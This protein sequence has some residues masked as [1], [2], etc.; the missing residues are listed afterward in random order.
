MENI[1]LLLLLFYLYSTTFR[2]CS[3]VIFTVL[4]FV[5]VVYG[6]YTFTWSPLVAAFL[7]ASFS[8]HHT[9]FFSFH[10]SGNRAKSR[11]GVSS[12]IP[13]M[14]GTLETSH[15]S[16]MLVSLNFIALP[17]IH[18]TSSAPLM[19]PESEGTCWSVCEKRKQQ[20]KQKKKKRSQQESIAQIVKDKKIKKCLTAAKNLIKLFR[21]VK[22]ILEIFHAADVPLSDWLVEIHQIVPVTQPIHVVD[23]WH[24]PHVWRTMRQLVSLLPLHHPRPVVPRRRE[25]ENRRRV[26]AVHWKER[27]RYHM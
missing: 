6:M 25:R 20:D 13:Y 12:S 27:K 16:K 14:P 8:L 18:C 24:V 26:S 10:S 17:N 1:W 4:T 3:L 23:C 22:R 19:S 11:E 21:I 9:A 2:G 7:T 15:F 5:V